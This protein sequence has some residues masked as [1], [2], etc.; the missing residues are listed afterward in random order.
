MTRPVL[1]IGRM[2]WHPYPKF[3]YWMQLRPFSSPQNTIDVP[4]LRTVA[5][6]PTNKR[7]LGRAAF[8]IRR[9][10]T[11]LPWIQA[12]R[13]AGIM[14]PSTLSSEMA[15]FLNQVPAVGGGDDA[16]LMRS[17]KRSGKGFSS[18]SPEEEEQEDAYGLIEEEDDDEEGTDDDEGAVIVTN[19]A[20]IVAAFVSL[21]EFV[22]SLLFVPFWIKS[23]FGGVFFIR[24]LMLGYVLNYFWQFQSVA[25][26]TVSRWLGGSSISGSGIVC[27]SAV[28]CCGG[29][30]S[31][32][33]WPPPTL[34]ALG[35]LT[36]FALIV[37][38]D[39]YTWI[40]LRKIRFVSLIL[41]FSYDLFGPI[42]FIM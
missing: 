25:E 32:G 3:I 16:V 39:G 24:T 33:A 27:A 28:E 6:E 38:P 11:K 40:I 30:N 9:K 36:I 41:L 31:K 19:A 15:A 26:H 35:V 5:N 42:M 2:T 8:R 34:V 23:I 1:S 22:V 18:M 10:R 12:G 17:S 13:P 29:G 14:P 37:H 7:L 20:P 4:P 21:F